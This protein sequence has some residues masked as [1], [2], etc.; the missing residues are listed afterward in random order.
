MLDLFRKRGVMSVVYSAL[1]GAVI[2][3]FVVEFRPNANSPVSGLTKKCVAK[4]RGTCIDEKDWKAQRYLLRG[5][6]DSPGTNWNKAAADS[7]VERTLLEQEAKRLGIRVTE[8]DVMNELVRWRVHVTVPSGMRI[9]AQQLGVNSDGVRWT[10]FGT[11]EKPFDQQTFEKVVQ[12]TTGQTVSEFV[13][14]QEQE[15]VAARMLQIVADQVKVGE[16]EAYDQYKHDRSTTTV[17]TVKLDPKFFADHFATT[18]QATIDKWAAEHKADVDAKDAAWPKDHEKRLLHP[19]HILIESKKDE[20]ADKKAA[21]KKKADELLAKVKA[22]EDFG[23]LAKENSSDPGSKD[24]GGEYDWTDG[25]EYVP[26]FRDGLAKLKPGESAVV[27][28]Q[29]GFHVIQVMARLDGVAAVAYPLWRDA[30]GGELAQQAADKIEA[31]VKGKIPVTLDAALKA[32]VEDAKKTGKPEADA[33]AIVLADEAKARLQKAIDDTLEAM[34]PPPVEKKPAAPAP[35][36]APGAK[37]P[38]PPPPVE[39]AW[40]KDD[41]KPR[42]DESS[43][44]PEGGSIVPAVAD[45]KPFTDAVDKLTKEAPLTAPIKSGT[46]IYIFA[47]RDKHTATREEFDKDKGPYMARLLG[48]KREDAILNYVTYLHET[49]AKEINVEQKYV[50][51]EKKG[52][53]GEANAPPPMPFDE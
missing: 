50:E 17:E 1:M 22:G 40:K 26:E 45:Q 10:Q 30:K 19:R 25:Y 21:A 46:D 34:S 13:D 24:K 20:P 51:G 6:Y 33:T 29:F 28:T 27:E 44:F 18:D 38:E 3:V 35:P 4:V 47:L 39:A 12:A 31:A 43:P 42:V 14:S 52:A 48:K 16:I 53:P 11:K 32:K 15:L 5:Q 36:P 41:R 49:F 8:D 37:P 9:Q 23:K 7:L 2:V